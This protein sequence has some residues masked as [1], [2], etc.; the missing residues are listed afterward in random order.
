MSQ[1]L[2]ADNHRLTTNLLQGEK[3]AASA[4]EEVKHSWEAKMQVGNLREAALGRSSTY[5]TAKLGIC[6]VLRAAS[7]MLLRQSQSPSF[8]PELICFTNLP[9]LSMHL[10]PGRARGNENTP[11]ASGT[12]AGAG[13]RALRTKGTKLRGRAVRGR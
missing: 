8:S 1:D 4:A 2:A 3:D 6:G 7:M 9:A 10:R 5:V 12:L 13:C 11:P